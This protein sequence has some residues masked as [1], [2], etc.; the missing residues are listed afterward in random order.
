VPL[1]AL[2][3]GAPDPVS[4]GV[5]RGWQLAGHRVAAIWYPQRLR[6][7]PAFEKD[8]AL[9]RTAPGVTLHGMA[10]RGGVA[11]RPVPPLAAWPEAIGEAASLCVDVV[12]SVL[13]LD[14]IPRTMLSAF[15]DRV[16]NLHPSLLPAYKGRWPLF[17]MLWDRAVDEHGGMTLH[18]VTPAF[19]A[20]DILGQTRVA[21]PADR[22]IAAYNMHLVKAGAG[23]LTELVPRYFVGEI[24]PAAQAPRQSPQSA[25]RPSQAVLTSS[26]SAEEMAWLCSTIPQVTPLRVEGAQEL[27]VVGF[28]ESIGPPTRAPPQRDGATVT[29]DARDRRVRL[30][31]AS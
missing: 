3:L 27:I 19:D 13:F 23:L 17:N 18:L 26:H 16:V 10:E 21:F 5:A 11:V 29:L 12:V 2:F 20:G 1:T 22:S 31:C 30:A 25:R 24:E 15:P 4:A 9:A 28:I 7:S 14:R 8:R 6:E